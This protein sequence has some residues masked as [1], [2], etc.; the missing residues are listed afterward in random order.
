MSD[1]TSSTGSFQLPA[2]IVELCDV[3]GKIV[4][5]E[6]LPLEPQRVALGLRDDGRLELLLLLQVARFEI[7]QRSAADAA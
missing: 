7:S 4:R 1:A 5:Q 3:A 6:L 2:E